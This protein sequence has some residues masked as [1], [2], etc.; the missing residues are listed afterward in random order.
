MMSLNLRSPLVIIQYKDPD[1][2]KTM[3][4]CNKVCGEKFIFSCYTVKDTSLIYLLRLEDFFS[5]HVKQE[6][7]LK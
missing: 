4:D 6:P 7:E 3:V 1:V 2:Y 5:L